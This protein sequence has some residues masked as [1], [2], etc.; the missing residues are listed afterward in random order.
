MELRQTHIIAMSHQPTIDLSCITISW[1]Y[2][3]N[4]PIMCHE[5]VHTNLINSNP[6]ITYRAYMASYL[7]CLK[8]KSSNHLKHTRIQLTLSISLRLKS[9]RSGERNPSPKLPVVAWVRLQIE[10]TSRSRS[11]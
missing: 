1:Q 3:T 10:G 5:F 7:N 4:H 6:N 8:H 2:P 9:S 11:S